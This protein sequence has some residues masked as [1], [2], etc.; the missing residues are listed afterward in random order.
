M[1]GCT[2]APASASLEN[3]FG[4][5][6]FTLES[7]RPSDQVALLDGLGYQGMTLFWPGLEAFEAF[8]ATPAG[9]EV[10]ASLR[11]EAD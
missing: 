1:L 6:N 10:A 3:P 9:R 8:V 2:K 7:R 4:A 11:G 5:F